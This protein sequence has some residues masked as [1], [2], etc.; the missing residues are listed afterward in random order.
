MLK[1]LLTNPCTAKLK[2][3]H[4]YS[5][6]VLSLLKNGVILHTAPSKVIPTLI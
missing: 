6:T 3:P 4:L 5:P 2:Y 1:D